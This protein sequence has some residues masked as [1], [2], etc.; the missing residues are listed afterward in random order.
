MRKDFMTLDVWKRA[1]LLALEICKLANKLPDHDE[2][3]GVASEICRT[4]IQIPAGIARACSLEEESEFRECLEEARVEL[5]HVDM[6]LMIMRDLGH[7]SPGA[8]DRLLEKSEEVREMF[9]RTIHGK[10]VSK[11]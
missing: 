7:L 1:H 9:D 5:R 2:E 11:T 8:C 10:K 3:F 4:A 6:Q